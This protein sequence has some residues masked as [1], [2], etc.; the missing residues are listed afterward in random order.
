[1]S[2]QLE[3]H[4]VYGQ[5]DIYQ[6][7]SQMKIHQQPAD[8]SIHQQPAT[9]DIQTIQGKL[10]IDQSGPFADEGLM[11]SGQLAKQSAQEGQQ[12]ALD[13][14]GKTAADGDRLKSD[15]KSGHAIAN[16]AD[17]NSRPPVHDFNV[18]LIP[19]SPI[20][21]SYQPAQVRVS[22]R[23]NKPDIN[24]KVNHVDIQ[25]EPGTVQVRMA[26]YPSISIQAVGTQFNSSV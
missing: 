8:L 24:I 4:Q 2:V 11:S 25:A 23:V 10:T 21:F 16:L 1:M 6:T 22:V 19:S 9:L 12:A 20:A 5:I 26:R 3:I 17:K 13:Y 14:I 15:I 18:T 7:Y